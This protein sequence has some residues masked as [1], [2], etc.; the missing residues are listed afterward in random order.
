MS[1]VNQRRI[2]PAV[3]KEVR[4][5][6]LKRLGRVLMFGMLVSVMATSII[7]LNQKWSIGSWEIKADAP[8]KAAIEAQLQAMP[9]RDF[10]STRPDQLREL[11]LQ[12]IPDLADVRITRILPDRLRIQAD[13]RLPVAL[14]QDEQS[15]LHLF[16]GHGN[17]YRLLKKGE[18][19]DLPLLRI[20]EEQLDAARKMIVALAQHDVQKLS[21]LSEIRAGSR[22]WKIYFSRG[23][24][25]L[26]PQGD[27][28]SMIERIKS[29]LQ[30]PRWRNRYWR[31]DAR[32]SSRWFIR[33][34]GHGGII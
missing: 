21:G 29:L 31:V 34:A 9:N 20:P 26:I 17:V 23:V 13:A 24:R 14:W 10:L 19:P 1:R 7:W 33:P 3:Q 28:G 5:R 15:R 8:L 18:S 27:E 25:W 32:L 22:H 12:R 6:N 2:D 11:W 30:Q 16:D 4:R